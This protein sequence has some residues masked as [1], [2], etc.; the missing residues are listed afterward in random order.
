M[1]DMFFKKLLILTN[2]YR[3]CAL[4]KRNFN[5]KIFFSI[6]F[7]TRQ[8]KCLNEIYDLFYDNSN[9]KKIIKPELFDYIDNISLAQ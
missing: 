2:A 6:S 3:A 8:L 7:R 4:I 9:N 1:F 5:K